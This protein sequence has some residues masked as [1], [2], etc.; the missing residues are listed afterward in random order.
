MRELPSAAPGSQR[1]TCT[2]RARVASRPAQ[3]ANPRPSAS[4]PPK[5]ILGVLQCKVSPVPPPTTVTAD[6]DVRPG[7]TPVQLELPKPE[8]VSAELYPP[9]AWCVHLPPAIDVFLPRKSTLHVSPQSR[10]HRGE[11]GAGKTESTKKV[12]QYLAAIA[13][14]AHPPTITPSHS[15]SLSLV[16]SSYQR[17][18]AE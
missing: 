13:T 16:T 4:G 17:F 2:V 5:A 12:I 1:G 10:K 14:D 15:Q 18:A 6:V 7:E 9:D 11:P 3:Q 8:T